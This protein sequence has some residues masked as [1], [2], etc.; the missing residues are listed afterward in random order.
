M[1]PKTYEQ[2]LAAVEK[3]PPPKPGTVY[4]FR[5]V[6]S[7]CLYL[8]RFRLE[9]KGFRGDLLIAGPIKEKEQTNVQ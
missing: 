2:I 6:E 3:L 9:P 5:S 8:Q 1:P 7:L 4:R